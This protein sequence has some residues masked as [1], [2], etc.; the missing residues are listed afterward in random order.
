MSDFAALLADLET[1]QKA[2][3]A[4][5][6]DDKKT[7]GDG[8]ADD[9]K[10]SAGDKKIVAAAKDGEKNSDAEEKE[11]FGKAFKVKL[12]DGTE[13]EAFDGTQMLKALH[14]EHE[15][16]RGAVYSRDEDILKAF[17]MA[18]GTIRDLQ[19][20]V[21]GQ[22]TI[23]KALQTKVDTFGAAGVGR[24]TMLTIA[25]KLSPSAGVT[26]SGEAERAAAGPKASDVMAKAKFLARE[27]KFDPA[28]LPRLEAHQMRGMI[29]PDDLMKA[30]P[31]LL[32]PIR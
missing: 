16:L 29:G 22:E 7:M 27:G 30:F 25:E 6:A 13:T 10:D 14:A 23:I 21:G 20:K 19:A 32:T 26:G 1:L 17:D 24:R 18:I 4:D 31:E 11:T 3:G 9:K 8:D 5:C 12:E 2:S 28:Q 15:V